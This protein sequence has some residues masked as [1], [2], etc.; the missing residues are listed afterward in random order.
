MVAMLDFLV[1]I[2]CYDSLKQLANSGGARRL[3]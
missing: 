2:G 3:K 1:A